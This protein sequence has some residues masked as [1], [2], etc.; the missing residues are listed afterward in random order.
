M[1]G[2]SHEIEADSITPPELEPIRL[3][4]LVLLR[5]FAITGQLAAV[6]AARIMGIQFPIGPVLALIA[7]AAI[8]NLW[9]ML[10]PHQRMSASQTAGQLS[11][12]LIQLSA[13]IGLT[14]GLVN[15]FGLLVLAPVTVAATV[16]D[17]RRTLALGIA[18][19][20][21]ITLASVLAVPLHDATGTELSMAPILLLGHWVALVIGV[22]FFA[23]YAHRVAAELKATSTAL[24]AT[25]MA[26]S[27]EQRLQHLGGVVAAAAHEMG[28][29]LATI[30]L[31]A[32]EL[33]DE[34]EDRPELRADA[35]ALRN[36]ADRCAQILRSMG[37]AGKEDLHLRS[38][39]VQAVLEDAAHP[40][41]DRGPVVEITGSGPDIRRDPGVIHALR[42]LIQNAVDFAHSRV[43]IDAHASADHLTVTIRDDGPGYS[44]AVLSRIGDPFVTSKRGG[45]QRSGYEG[46]GLGM[47][48]AKT[49]LERSGASLTVANA[50]PGALVTVRWPLERIR[51]TS[52]VALGQNPSFDKF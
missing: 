3:R 8:I 46:M 45:A 11:F 4:T 18:T 33:G 22:V 32:G 39:P 40:H 36:S 17:R 29:P 25:Q 26:L 5:W 15:P 10:K 48:I 30:K 35:M 7:A 13:L 19:I 27:R 52:R 20:I 44:P 2:F 1:T 9:Q 49:L 23:V 51:A 47:F 31:I 12:D 41:A 38:A 28:T 34:L 6:F 24:F 43:V 16:L 14:G 50:Q 37:R 21:L 42:N